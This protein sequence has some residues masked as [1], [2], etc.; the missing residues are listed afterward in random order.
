MILYI[1]IQGNLVR[2]FPAA[3]NFSNTISPENNEDIFL[4]S[5]RIDQNWF[6]KLLDLSHHF[7]LLV[8][9]E[10]FLFRVKDSMPDKLWLS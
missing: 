2:K 3:L 8:K 6:S 1:F 4:P 9:K 7:H 5:V 10:Y